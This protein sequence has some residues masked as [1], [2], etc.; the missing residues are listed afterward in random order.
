MFYLFF[1]TG[2]IIWTIERE[3]CGQGQFI[4]KEFVIT[5]FV[6]STDLI[7]TSPIKNSISH[8]VHTELIVIKAFL[9]PYA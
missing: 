6:V 8:S 3:K 1:S 5:C 2:F 4:I 9:L 7:I